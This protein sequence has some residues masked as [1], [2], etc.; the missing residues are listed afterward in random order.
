MIEQKCLINGIEIKFKK[1]NRKYDTQHLIVIFSGF[2][3]S[4]EFTYD[5]ENALQDCPANVLWI[6]DD[7]NDHCTYYLCKN[8][9]FAVEN[10]IHDF[11]K[12]NL[13]E[14]NLTKAQCTVA[15]FSK[16]GSAAL[17]YGSKYNIKNILS[18]VPQ[19]YVGSYANNNWPVVANH[20]MGETTEQ[21][22]NAIDRLIPN[23]IMDDKILDKNIYLITSKA[24]KQYVPEIEPNISALIKYSNF[25]LLLSTSILVREHNQVTVHHLPLILGIMYSL[26]QGAVPRYGY[27]ELGGDAYSIPDKPSGTPLTVLKNVKIQN[28]KFYPEGVAILRG[29]S[30]AENKDIIIRLHLVN[31]ENTKEIHLAKG[32]KPYLT[33]F[34]YDGNFVNYDKGWFCSPSHAGFILD[35]VPIGEYQLFIVVTCQGVTKKNNLTVDAPLNNKSLAEGNNVK[36]FSKDGKVFLHKS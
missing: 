20:M 29:L 10:A 11:I 1:K 35:E 17:Y 28:G 15:G 5:F 9:D 26:A 30:C 2:G 21:N 31:H 25:N 7:F 3:G 23:A 13:E 36:I 32:H 12:L 18:T 34:L 22:I 14:L 4:G 27:T 8:M 33:R 24:D 16:G 6:K 19:F